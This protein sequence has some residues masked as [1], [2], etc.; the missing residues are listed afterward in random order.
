MNS[1]PM[2]TIAQPRLVSAANLEATELPDGPIPVS[3][4]IS[5]DRQ[6]SPSPND[7][8]LEVAIIDDRPLLCDCFGRSLAAVEPRLNLK[9]FVDVEAFEAAP[10]EQ[11]SDVR[12][13]LLCMIWSK[14]R[15]DV[16]LSQITRLK[17]ADP[18]ADV[19]V[20]SDIDDLDDVLKAIE[21]GMR[22][23]IPTSD[24][25]AV[26]VKAIQLVAA[27][28]VYI[29]PSLLVWSGRLIKEMSQAPKQQPQAEDAFTS[30][31]MAVLEAVR[32][33]KANKMIAYELNMCESTVKVHIRNVMKKLKAKNRT[34]LA[35]IFNNKM[36]QDL[37]V[38]KSQ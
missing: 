32:R 29:P 33:G 37:I 8:P 11:K 18:S 3:T 6:A 9:Y 15:A 26:A 24:R 19:I 30:R 22:G 12:V 2:T 7:Q 16:L 31:Q 28:G 4:S 13:V 17:S 14:S 20:V 23:Y 35:F 34:E 25:L 10:A 27:G 1:S 38:N 36:Q 5:L 21:H